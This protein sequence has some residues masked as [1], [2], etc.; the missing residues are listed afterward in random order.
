MKNLTLTV[1]VL[2][3][4]LV[5]GCTDMTASLWDE[6]DGGLGGRVGYATGNTEVGGSF[7]Y[8]PDGENANAEVFGAYGL[9][10]FP[11]LVEIPLPIQAEF[12]PETIM[13][14]P[15]IGAK[16][17]IDGNASLVIAGVE[18][19]NTLFMEYQDT[20]ILIGLKHKF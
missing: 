15:Y 14:T 19:E 18:I 8:W 11:E 3:L 6:R 16:I 4:L 13:A 5:A 10:K 12:L 7:L 9:Y 20:Y 1:I 2:A 17:D